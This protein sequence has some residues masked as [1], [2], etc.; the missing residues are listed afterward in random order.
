MDS[1]QEESE[2]LR[3]S[4][5]CLTYLTFTALNTDESIEGFTFFSIMTFFELGVFDM[6][7]AKWIH[8]FYICN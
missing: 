5:A 1:M 8:C 6:S 3:P 7:P 4:G 2:H